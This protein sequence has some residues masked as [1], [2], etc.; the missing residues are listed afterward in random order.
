MSKKSENIE[1]RTAAELRAKRESG[2]ERTDWKRAASLPLP[3]GS[4]PTV[5]P[6]RHCGR[7]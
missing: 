4:D 7:S 5:A 2:E 3:D 6:R 1:T